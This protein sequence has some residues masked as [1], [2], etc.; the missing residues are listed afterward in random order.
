M[1]IN[2]YICQIYKILNKNTFF[3]K[4]RFIFYYLCIYTSN[5]YTHTYKHTYKHTYMHRNIQIF[6]QTSVIY[7][8]IYIR[9]R[10]HT[11][12]HT[13]MCTRRGTYARKHSLAH[14]RTYALTHVHLYVYVYVYSLIN[15]TKNTTSSQFRISCIFP[16]SSH[17]SR[18]ADNF[19]RCISRGRSMP[20][21]LLTSSNQS[22][23][24]AAA[25]C[26]E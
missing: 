21:P 24:Y 26:N 5:P 10:G 8:Y 3:T 17:V 9:T 20:Q 23:I 19:A 18:I 14:L 11:H 2:V 16:S 25:H 15:T 4:Q 12:G 6:M 1:Y 13:Y 7:I 22:I